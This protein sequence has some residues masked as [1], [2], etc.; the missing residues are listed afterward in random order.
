MDRH[1]IANMGAE[2]G[3]TSTVFPSD[4]QTRDYLIKQGRGADW[5]ALA[6]DEG[7]GYDVAG[8]LDLSELEPLIALPPSP[9]APTLGQPTAGQFS[10]AYPTRA[11]GSPGQPVRGQLSA[12]Q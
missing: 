2:L 9:A 12:R 1:M 6:A 3:A 8:E 11:A 4:H 7:A 10:D 5:A